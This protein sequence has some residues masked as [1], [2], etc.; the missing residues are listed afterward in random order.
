MN[1]THNYFI[2]RDSKNC[3][4]RMLPFPNRWLLY[5]N[6]ML[7][8]ETELT[9]APKMTV[10]LL[11]SE[12]ENA[13]R[14]KSIKC[15]VTYWTKQESRLR[16]GITDHE[17]TTCAT[18]LPYGRLH[19]WQMAVWIFIVRCLSFPPISDISRW[20]QQISTFA[21]QPNSIPVWCIILKIFLLTFSQHLKRYDTNRFF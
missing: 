12:D 17:F 9:Q 19:L 6:N 15:S 7:H 1:L 20:R 3:K 4:E 11:P 21:W 18:L 14:N 5:S 10:S 13:V 8:T 2:I 16:A